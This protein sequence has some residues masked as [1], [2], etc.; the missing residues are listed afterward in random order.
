MDFNNF[1]LLNFFSLPFEL[2]PNS[3]VTPVCHDTP[4]ENQCSS[5]QAHAVLVTQKE[6]RENTR[7]TSRSHRQMGTIS[8]YT[9]DINVETSQEEK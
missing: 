4:V 2:P 5:N 6:G 1:L 7:A 8:C 9:T 3:R